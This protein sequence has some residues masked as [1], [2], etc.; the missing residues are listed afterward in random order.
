MKYDR[1]NILVIGC[2][3]EPF[4]QPGFIDFCLDVK[5]EK[6]CGTVIHAGD[7]FDSYNISLRDIDPDD[8]SPRDEIIK[9]RKNLKEWYKAFPKV[10]YTPGNHCLRLYRK[11]KKFGI[12]DICMRPL[13]EIWE[14]PRGWEIRHEFV[15]D[16]VL[17]N[18]GFSATKDAAVKSAIYNRMSTVQAHGHTT[19]CTSY[20]ASS[21]DCIFGMSVGTGIDRSAMAFAYGRGFREKPIVSC[22]TVEY[23]ENPH[24]HRMR[25]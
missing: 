21:R 17:Y 6:R 13:R 24:V 22:G 9:T 11:A 23:G 19:A 2:T 16:R 5:R 3:H 10:K 14:I 12:P 15:I 18:H 4:T 25:L 1:H 20:S 8:K 7:L